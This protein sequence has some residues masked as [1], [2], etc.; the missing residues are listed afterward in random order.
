MTGKITIA[1]RR[2]DAA[3]EQHKPIAV[4]GLFSG[5]HDS[6]SACYIASQHPAFTA[7]VHI[8]TGTGIKATRDYVIKTCADRG[9]NLLEYKAAENVNAKGEPDPQIYADLVRRDGFPGPHGHGMMYARLKE[10]QLRRLQREFGATAKRG[11]ERRVLYVSGCRSQ[12]SDRRMGNTDEVQIDGPRIWCAPI[13]DWAK[14]ETRYLLEH[15]DQ[16][17]N[18]VVDLIHKSGE[19]LCGAFAKKG[20]LEELNCWPHTRDAYLQIKA[21]EA[22]VVPIHGRG[23]G[24]RPQRGGKN[25]MRI[26]GMLCWSCDKM[27][28]LAQ[29]ERHEAPT[30]TVREKETL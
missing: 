27:P 20:E 5:G 23:W 15:A 18:P 13:H 25:Q 3:I 21:L 7:A 10:R 14:I 28:T 1:L 30:P 26:P 16:P 24:E 11:K 9:W 8:N 22:E 19:C 17:S 12:E 4:F 2:L 6:F 29:L